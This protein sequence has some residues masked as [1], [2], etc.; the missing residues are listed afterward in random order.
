MF[1]R[2]NPSDLND[3]IKSNKIMTKK[4]L[5]QRIGMSENG[6]HD[7]LVNKQT[8]KLTTF[9]DICDILKVHPASFFLMPGQG[10]DN[11][12][13]ASEPEVFYQK[14]GSECVPRELYREMKNRYEDEIKYLRDQNRILSSRG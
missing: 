13:M 3:F 2:L 4:D 5:S 7:A 12:T 11:L 8:L 10:T 6:L 14:G 1:K 9:Q